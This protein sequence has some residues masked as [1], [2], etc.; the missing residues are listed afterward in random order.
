MEA[1]EG[2]KKHIMMKSNQDYIHKAIQSLV[3]PKMIGLRKKKKDTELHT[4]T[5]IK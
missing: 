1:A 4:H 3:N 2:K 5:Q